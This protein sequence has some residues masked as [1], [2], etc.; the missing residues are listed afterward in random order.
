MFVG[1]CV[2]RLGTVCVLV[3]H[4]S[5]TMSRAIFVTL[6]SLFVLSAAVVS[7]GPL[8][9]RNHVGALNQRLT[10]AEHETAFRALPAQWVTQPLD[11]NDFTET[12]MWQQK[13]Y[14]NDTYATPNGPVFL[15][16]GG[17]GPMSAAYLNGHFIIGDLAAK[18]GATQLALEHRFYGESVPLNDSSSSNLRYLTSAQAL[19]D[20]VSFREHII[21]LRPELAA[22]TWIV[23]GGSYSGSLAAWARLKYPHLFHGAFAASAPVQAQLDFPQYFEVVSRS[24]G[25]SCSARIGEST[26]QVTELLQT[27]DGRSKLQQM[28]GLCGPIETDN[29]VVIFV[30]SLSDPIAGVVQYNQD[31]NSYQPFDITEMCRMLEESSDALQG[32]VTVFNAYNK[33]SGQTECTDINY[34]NY[35]KYMQQ[36]SAGRSWTWQTCNEFGYYQTGESKDQPFSPILSLQS[37]LQQCVDIFGISDF[38]PKVEYINDYYGGK[39]IVTTNTA[40]TNGNVDPWSALGNYQTYPEYAQSTTILIEGTA[41]CADLY[42]PR[43]Q[44]LPGL[45]AARQQQEALLR[46]WLGLDPTDEKKQPTPNVKLAEQ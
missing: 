30:G 7:A 31:N 21:S 39:N 17:E 6:V 3:S 45:V 25:A 22:S 44:D 40:F 32:L 36:T 26:A 19:Q 13:Y 29:D 8:N 35:I 37:F 12:R 9:R 38:T 24:V 2:H 23:F 20:L 41:H 43:E 14:V 28:F 10:R 18:Y 46:K 34:D 15:M 16:I 42:P 5:I 27:S 1:L 33:Y 11:H 4:S